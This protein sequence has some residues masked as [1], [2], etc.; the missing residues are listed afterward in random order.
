MEGV[1]GRGSVEG[2]EAECL[3]Q[4]RDCNW[5]GANVKWAL[6]TRKMNWDSGDWA[7]VLV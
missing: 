5:G 2:R 1:R 4:Q 6:V 7:S 3:E